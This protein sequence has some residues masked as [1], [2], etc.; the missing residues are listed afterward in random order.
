MATAYGRMVTAEN[1]GVRFVDV[2][3][4]RL[5]GVEFDDTNPIAVRLEHVRQGGKDNVVVVDLRHRQGAGTGTRHVPNVTSLGVWQ[6]PPR[7]DRLSPG[8]R[9]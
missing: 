3:I 2:V 1:R 5:V 6:Y 8:P 9:P 7:G 4:D